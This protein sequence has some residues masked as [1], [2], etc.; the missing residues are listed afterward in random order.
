MEDGSCSRAPLPDALLGCSCWTQTH[1]KTACET[2]SVNAIGFL[3]DL[4]LN[5]LV[6]RFLKPRAHQHTVVIVAQ[7]AQQRRGGVGR[8]IRQRELGHQLPQKS[9]ETAC[10]ST[11][12]H[13]SRSAFVSSVLTAAVYASAEGLAFVCLGRQQRQDVIESQS[14]HGSAGLQMSSMNLDH[15]G[16]TTQ[17]KS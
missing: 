7:R 12:N 1:Q 14:H 17:H 8:V 10:Q 15:C 11:A 2:I 5:G 13:Q 9:V 6:I 16:N 3:N 4:I